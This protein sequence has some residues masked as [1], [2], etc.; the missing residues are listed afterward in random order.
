MVRLATFG[1]GC[2]WCIE[3][4]FSRLNGVIEVVLRLRRRKGY[5]EI[6][7]N[8]KGGIKILEENF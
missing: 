1:G 5:Y 4:A 2:F 3:E 8:R 7:C 6:V